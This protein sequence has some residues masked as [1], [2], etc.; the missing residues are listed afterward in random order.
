MMPRKP[1]SVP[2]TKAEAADAKGMPN[3]TQTTRNAA[4][5]P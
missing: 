3:A 5:T 1:E 2:S 4:I